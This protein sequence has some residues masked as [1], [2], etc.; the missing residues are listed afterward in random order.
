MLSLAAALI[1]GSASTKVIVYPWEITQQD[2]KAIRALERAVGARSARLLSGYSSE[3]STLLLRALEDPLPAVRLT[4][5]LITLR[6]LENSE[7][8]D[9]F[10]KEQVAAIGRK[11]LDT[12]PDDADQYSG[13]IVDFARRIEWHVELAR[14]LQNKQIELL[15]EALDRS[16]RDRE[17]YGFLAVERL[18]QIGGDSAKAVIER[19]LQD[20]DLTKDMTLRLEFGRRKISFKQHMAGMDH[21]EKI[22]FIE[23][24]FTGLGIAADRDHSS[25]QTTRDYGTWILSVASTV[26]SEEATVFLKRVW[27]DASE[28]QWLRFEAQKHVFERGAAGDLPEVVVPPFL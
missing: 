22:D 16:D 5:L 7:V 6:A 28:D 3:T 20:D 26:D 14:S 12:P 13:T 11:F 23:R 25:A 19:K 4:S 9:Y 2:S 10:I 27:M 15:S 17:Y 8:P 18:V 21:G 1:I 24:I